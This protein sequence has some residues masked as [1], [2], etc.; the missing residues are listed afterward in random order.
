MK[1][2]KNCRSFSRADY[3][4]STG[5]C[6]KYRRVMKAKSSCEEWKSTMTPKY[7]MVAYQV[8]VN[9]INYD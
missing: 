5:W 7:E 2:C 6:M 9:G 4:K 1:M 8:N 3:H